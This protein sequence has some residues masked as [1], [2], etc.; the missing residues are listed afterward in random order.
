[1]AMA[2]SELAKI[3]WSFLKI[4]I[5]YA[6]FPKSTISIWINSLML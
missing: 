2:K 6:T 3:Y 1:M 5:V 4:S